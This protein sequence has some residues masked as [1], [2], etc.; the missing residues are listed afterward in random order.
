VLLA[1]ADNLLASRAS[2]VLKEEMDNVCDC[3][4]PERC[5]R[6]DLCKQAGSQ[7]LDKVGIASLE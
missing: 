1:K 3:L 4:G 7:L 5:G 6:Y 2:S